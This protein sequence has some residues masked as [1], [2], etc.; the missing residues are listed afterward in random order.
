M[1]A[2]IQYKW[3]A[4]EYPDENDINAQRMTINFS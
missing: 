1:N 3:L 2:Y 4:N